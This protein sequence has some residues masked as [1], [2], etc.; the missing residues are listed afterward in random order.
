MP[1]EQREIYSDFT[2]VV[3]PEKAGIHNHRPLLLH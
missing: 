1:T 3:V 2:W